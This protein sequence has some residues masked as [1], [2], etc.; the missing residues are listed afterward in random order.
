MGPIPPHP[1]ARGGGTVHTLRPR[2]L[3]LPELREAGL[4]TADPLG[5]VLGTKESG[6]RL[7]GE[8]R[9]ARGARSPL[10]RAGLAGSAPAASPEPLSPQLPIQNPGSAPTGVSKAG[11]SRGITGGSGRL[12]ELGWRQPHGAPYY[13]LG[14]SW[15]W[16]LLTATG[17][18]GDDG[19]RKARE[20]K[21]LVQGHTARPRQNQGVNPG[22]LAPSQGFLHETRLLCAQDTP[23]P[24]PLP[25]T[26]KGTMAD[27]EDNE[28][29]AGRGRHR[30]E[31]VSCGKPLPLT[32]RGGHWGPWAS[33]SSGVWGLRLAQERREW[34]SR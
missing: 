3:S 8:W 22:N 33:E 17:N 31:R 24:W 10:P 32:T 29:L 5:F 28:T 12:G 6:S 14:T 2:L 19:K 26:E 27:R 34:G 4:R 30:R 15:S 9:G 25:K 20:G 18:V 23:V 7:S 13:V 16:V 11:R 21:G 1:R